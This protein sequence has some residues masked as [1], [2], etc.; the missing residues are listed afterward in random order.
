[1]KKMKLFKNM[2]EFEAIGYIED[3]REKEVYVF[4][5]HNCMM[6]FLYLAIA[7]LREEG[8]ITTLGIRDNLAKLIDNRF[9]EC[10]D[11]EEVIPTAVHRGLRKLIE[12]E[13]DDPLE[14]LDNYQLLSKTTREVS[15]YTDDL[16]S[17][18]SHR[19]E[20]FNLIHRLHG[21]ARQEVLRILNLEQYAK[22][23]NPFVKVFSWLSNKLSCYHALG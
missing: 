18:G 8:P 21:V 9:S 13:T 19:Y 6:C 10:E 16:W 11:E 3:Q 20:R 23:E 14:Q 17:S 5:D 15:E 7:T 2:Y 1:M 4:H 12:M 22:R